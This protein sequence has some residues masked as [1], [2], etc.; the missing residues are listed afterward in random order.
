MKRVQWYLAAI[1]LL[2]LM[3]CSV[4]AQDVHTDYD[5]HANFEQF[6]TYSWAKVQTDDPLWQSRITDAVDK[7]LQAKGWQKVDSGG[8][9]LLTAVGAVKN[10]QQYQTFYDGM[11][12]GWF[13]G[14]FGSESTTTVQNYKV[15]T[16]VLD[17]FDAQSKHLIWRGSASDTL[18]SKPE[19]N[20]NKLDKAVDKMFKDFPPKEK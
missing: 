3:A 14:G 2:F 7:D 13:W 19:K 11:G 6:H 15:G 20:E 1:P 5:H 9:V 8:Q 10:Q 16:L 4:F 12:P 18:T 17:M